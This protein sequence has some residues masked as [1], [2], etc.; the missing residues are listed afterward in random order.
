[1]RCPFCA[2]EIQ[3]AAIVCRFC[4]AAKRDGDW[5]RPDAGSANPAKQTKVRGH[6][7]LRSAGALLILSAIFEAFSIVDPVPLFGDVRGG[8]VAISYHALFVTVFAL[9]GFGLWRAEP[10]GVRAVL[11]GT[12]IYV[13]DHVLF[14]MDDAAR[15]AAMTAQTRGY[16]QILGVIDLQ[17]VDRMVTTVALVVMVC[18]IGF[19]AYVYLRR[20]YFQRH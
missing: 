15:S 12:V 19:A 3:E 11:I 13:L 7:T 6:F 9:M 10:W 20:D 18:W 4:G 14:V 8:L 5:E 16:E 1:M 17:S 2:E